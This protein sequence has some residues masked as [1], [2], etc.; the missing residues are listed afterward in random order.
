MDNRRDD[1]YHEEPEQARPDILD[2]FE[3]TRGEF[4]SHTREPG[5][6]LNDGKVQVNTACIR[7]MA[8]VDY[9]Q[10][11]INR[12]THKLAIRACGEEDLLLNGYLLPRTFA[13][14][15]ILLQEGY[16]LNHSS[17]KLMVT[18]VVDLH[19]IWTIHKQVEYLL[20]F[21]CVSFQQGEAK[22]VLFYINFNHPN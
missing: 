14:I 22:I 1:M 17:A 3:V 8:D 16:I 19:E 6:T 9:I 4:Y 5:F 20:S 2:V 11:L 13:A 10:I 12:E 15:A 7:K 21:F 18:L